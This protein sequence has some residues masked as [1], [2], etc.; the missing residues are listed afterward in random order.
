MD[1]GRDNCSIWIYVSFYPLPHLT[2]Q[3]QSERK[4]LLNFQ[5]A[6]E[7]LQERNLPRTRLARFIFQKCIHL[8]IVVEASPTSPAWP[9]RKGA[10]ACIRAAASLQL[11]QLSAKSHFPHLPS[12]QL[13]CSYT[14]LSTIVMKEQKICRSQ[15]KAL[16]VVRYQSR[17]SKQ[18][19]EKVR[20]QGSRGAPQGWQ[21]E[22]CRT[23]TEAQA[24][25]GTTGQSSHIAPLSCLK[26]IQYN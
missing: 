10:L 23:R 20:L 17:K 9:Q 5:G 4:A 25:A 1:S 12:L 19:L 15:D 7:L 18:V 13:V 22:Q 11:F 2:G 6:Q 24:G 8:R 3:S 21:E 16:V 14:R 26:A